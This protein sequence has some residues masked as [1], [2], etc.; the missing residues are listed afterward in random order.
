MTG[1]R[2]GV[3]AHGFHP[4]TKAFFAG[5][6]VAVT[7]GSGFI[8]SHVVEQLL[9]LGARVIVPCRSSGGYATHSGTGVEIRRADLT[10]Q[11][12]CRAALDG[13]QVVMH[14]AADVAGLAYNMAHPASIF[15]ANMRM[16]LSVLAACRDLAVERVLVCSSA[17]VYPRYCS[18]PTPEEEGFKDEPEPTNG[19]YGWSKRMLEFLGAQYASEYGMSVAIGRPYNA[20]GPRDTFDPERSHVIPALIRKAVEARDGVVKVWGDGKA[21]RSFVYVDDFARGLIEV[22]ARHAKADPINIGANEETTI[23]ELAGLIAG[24]V[25]ERTGRP[26]RLEFDTSAPTGQPRRHCDTT[27]A[28]RL[29]GFTA[30]V[31][32]AEGMAKT[33]DWYLSQ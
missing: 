12:S 19:G 16:G 10:D 29:L 18:V 15:D 26:L 2:S 17:C 21:S 7:G 5:K 9:A 28:E 30:R 1:Y 31:G 6:R 13:A 8:G 20:Y 14:L 25:A 23:G 22:A 24:Q 33:I 27:K 11:Q 3:G 4:D 32:L